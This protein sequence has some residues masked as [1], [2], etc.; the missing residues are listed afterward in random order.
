[1]QAELTRIAA[2]KFKKLPDHKRAVWEEKAKRLKEEY[3]EKM[4]N[5]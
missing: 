3:T 1:L 2:D 4:E 5:F